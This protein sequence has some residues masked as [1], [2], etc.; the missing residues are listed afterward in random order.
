MALPFILTALSTGNP[1]CIGL[2]KSHL[3]SP[4]LEHA[5]S[6]S[7]PSSHELWQSAHL[8]SAQCSGLNPLDQVNTMQKLGFIYQTD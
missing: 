7:M 5:C 6:L 4:H 1:D 3:E 2:S 8:Y